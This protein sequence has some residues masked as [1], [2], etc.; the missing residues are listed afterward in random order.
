[1]H[2]NE[3]KHRYELFLKEHQDKV[4][5][6]CQA[7]AYYPDLTLDV[8]QEVLINL[9]TSWKSF[10]G[11]SKLTTW[12][13]RITVNTVI[14]FNK[15]EKKFRNKEGSEYTFDLP[16]DD[17]TKKEKIAHEQAL[18]K[19]HL[20]ISKLEKEERII[21]GL[22]LEDISYKEIAEV[23]GTD[24][25]FVGVKINRIKKKLAAQLA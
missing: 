6:I 10:Q 8:F 14:T 17:S 9:W 7:Y 23:L 2:D 15:K 5:R 20:A 19:M 18:D 21:V 13:Y 1:M 25:N 11:K 12:M 3:I 4:Y 22:Y 16:E 24:T